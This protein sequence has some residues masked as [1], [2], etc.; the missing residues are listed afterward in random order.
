MKKS[1]AIIYENGGAAEKTLAL[2]KIERTGKAMLSGAELAALLG[3]SKKWVDKHVYRIAG[4][5]KVGGSRK[6][7]LQIIKMRLA[8]GQDILI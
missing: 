5:Q 6:Y 1:K 8:L 7:D 2:E 3:L 4:S